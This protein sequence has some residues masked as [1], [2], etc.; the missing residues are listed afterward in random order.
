MLSGAEIMVIESSFEIKMTFK[1]M[2]AYRVMIN[3][4]KTDG[5]AHLLAR[6]EEQCCEDLSENYT[7]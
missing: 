4:H 1:I 7:K 6:E 5:V 3:Y 2:H